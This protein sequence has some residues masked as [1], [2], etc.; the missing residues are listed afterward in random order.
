MLGLWRWGSRV[1]SGRAYMAQEIVVMSAYAVAH[2]R[3]VTMNADI[4]RYLT[5]IDETLAPFHGRFA[6]HG[7]TV[8]VLEGEWPGHLLMIEFPDREAAGAWYRSPAYQ[9]IVQ[10]RLNNSIGDCILVDG[11]PPEHRATDILDG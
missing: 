11:V 4:V 1:A 6:V 10:L 5:L 8:E 2:I 9:A 7:G 3:E